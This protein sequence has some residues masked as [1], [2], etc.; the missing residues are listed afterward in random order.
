M[1]SREDAE[2]FT[3]ALEQH[4]GADWRQIWL[5]VKLG[6][7]KALGLSTEDWRQQ[8]LGGAFRIPVEERRKAALEMKAD[9]LS[10]REAAAVLGVDESTV[11]A[12]AGAGNPAPSPDKAA[13]PLATDDSG[14]GNPAPRPHVTNNS[15]EN[16]WYTPAEYI[17]AAREAMRQIDLDPASSAEANTIVKAG[18]FYTGS[19]DGLSREWRGMVWMNPPYSGGLIGPFCEKLVEHVQAGDVPA[20]CVLVNNATETEWFQRL[21]AHSAAVCLLNR[22]VRYWHPGRGSKTP[23]QGQAIV[24]F[25]AEPGR[26]ADAFDT[27]GTVL[28]PARTPP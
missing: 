8:R 11:R 13:P 2:E 3:G 14:A 23:L 27:L 26:F 7:P 18:A 10:N 24:Y 17:E 4:L 21:I 22:R 6:V 12:D 1:I 19:D 20:A 25:G 15:G 28:L 5:G 16:E 9:G